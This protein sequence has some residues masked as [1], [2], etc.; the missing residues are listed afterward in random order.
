MRFDTDGMLSDSV[1]LKSVL[2]SI[3]TDLDK[4]EESLSIITNTDNWDA[5]SRDYLKEESK[6]LKYN[7]DE[8]NN[9]FHNINQYVNVVIDNYVVVEGQTFF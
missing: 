4:I 8:V 3:T 6:R 9:K 5:E 1:T 2:D 7:F